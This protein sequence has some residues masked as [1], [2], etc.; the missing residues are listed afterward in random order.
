MRPYF[1]TGMEVTDF[2]NYPGIPHQ[3]NQSFRL[4]SSLMKDV[5]DELAKTYINPKAQTAQTMPY[6]HHHGTIVL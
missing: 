5:S 6:F 2:Q 1:L 4:A 3:T